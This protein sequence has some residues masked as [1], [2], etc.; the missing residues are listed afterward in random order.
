MTS[1][2]LLQNVSNKTSIKVIQH[3]QFTKDLLKFDQK[4]LI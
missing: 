1:T 3:V 2:Y 4:D